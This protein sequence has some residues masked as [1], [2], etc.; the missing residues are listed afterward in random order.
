MLARKIGRH[1]LAARDALDGLERL[2]IHYHGSTAAFA[3]L[4]WASAR[5]ELVLLKTP[6]FA[7]LATD[8][9]A[10]GGEG[11]GDIDVRALIAGLDRVQAID[12]ISK[13]LAGEIAR[14][15][16][17]PA[18]EVDRHRP[19]SELG[20]DSL[21]ALELRMA[22]EQRLGIDIPLMSIANGA[23][24]SDIAGKVT[25]RVLG[26][27]GESGLSDTAETLYKQHVGEVGGEGSDIAA[28]AEA[29]EEKSQSV[30]NMLK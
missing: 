20:M 3:H 18:E 27:E 10:E 9:E 22:A 12:A 17:L 16:R 21:M 29:V 5:K 14:I 28:I 19:L 15:L 4:D 13:L 6:L 1:T 24:L 11:G 23:T 7:D 2:L 26:E 30:R 8:I 25:A